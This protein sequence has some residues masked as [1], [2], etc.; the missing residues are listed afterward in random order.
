MGVSM[1]FVN[2]RHLLQFRAACNGKGCDLQ[3]FLGSKDQAPISKSQR[4]GLTHE[5]ALPLLGP[6][7]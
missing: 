2:R 7:Q 1:K 4:S 5:G 6:M 3:P